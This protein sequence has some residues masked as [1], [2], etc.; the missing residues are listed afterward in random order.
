MGKFLMVGV[1]ILVIAFAANTLLNVLGRFSRRLVIGVTF[2]IAGAGAYAASFVFY[3]ITLAW[4]GELPPANIVWPCVTWSMIALSSLTVGGGRPVPFAALATPFWLIGGLAMFGS[5]AHPRNLVTAIAL[6]LGGI[7]YGS[8]AAERAGGAAGITEE[9]AQL[10]VRRGHA[11]TI[12]PY[13]LDM[14]TGDLSKLVELTP[15]ER[16]AL[17][18]AVEFK[19]ERIYHA[20]LASFADASWEIVLGA[21]D[22]R[23]YKVSALLVLED[24]GQRDRMWRNLDGLLRTPLGTPAAAAANIITWDTEDGNVVMNRADAGVAYA[25]VLT[26]TSRAVS[27]FVRIK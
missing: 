21:V 18:V 1:T 11:P 22:N 10:K 13:R 7:A 20:P 6:I 25:V 5:L 4:A 19:S 3:M 2:A 15:S 12:G 9:R 23:V 17:N 26:L 14:N 16:R 24:H 27:G 8:V